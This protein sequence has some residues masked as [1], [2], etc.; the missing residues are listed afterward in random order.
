MARLTVVEEFR[1]RLDD[2][3]IPMQIYPGAE[4][5]VDFGLPERIMACEGLTINGGGKFAIRA[6]GYIIQPL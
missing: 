6:L 1:R 3:Y 5:V 2:E 4:L